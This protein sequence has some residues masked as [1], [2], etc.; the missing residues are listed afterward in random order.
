[1]RALAWIAEQR[2]RE[3]MERGDFDNLPLRGKPLRLDDY[4]GLPEEVRMVLALLHE[5]G[6]RRPI[7]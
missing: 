3:A 4:E 1:V 6:L 7:R 5:A 2:I